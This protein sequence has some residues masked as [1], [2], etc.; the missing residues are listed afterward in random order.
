EEGLCHESSSNGL[1]PEQDSRENESVP[2]EEVVA[3]CVA[4]QV[5]APALVDEKLGTT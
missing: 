5:E 1:I 4:N 2:E 3:I